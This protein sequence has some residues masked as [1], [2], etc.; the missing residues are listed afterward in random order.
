MKEREFRIIPESEK[1]V[2]GKK[3]YYDS[4][5]SLSDEIIEIYG[6][7]IM[8]MS[9]MYK[10]GEILD[11]DTI[12]LEEYPLKEAPGNIRHSFYVTEDLLFT[13]VL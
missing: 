12:L 4:W 10:D 6:K 5:S 9:K 13:Y 3:Y 11:V 7:D 1:L 8:R 2:P